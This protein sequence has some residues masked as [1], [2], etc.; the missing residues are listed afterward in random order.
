MK[1]LLGTKHHKVLH[2]RIQATNINTDIN[3]GEY[4]SDGLLSYT[5]LTG[6]EQYSDHSP[7]LQRRC[8]ERNSKQGESS[9]CIVQ[10]KDAAF[11]KRYALPVGILEKNKCAKVLI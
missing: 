10:Q 4:K 11:S 6:M 9:F 1:R 3:I 8:T 5:M 7:S 2:K